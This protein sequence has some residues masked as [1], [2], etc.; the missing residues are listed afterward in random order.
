MALNEQRF[1]SPAALVDAVYDWSLPLLQQAIT[2]Q[3]RCSLLLSGGTTPLPYYRKLAAAPLPWPN[4]QLALVDERW[5]AT[6]D[7]LSNELAIRNAFASNPVAQQQILGMKNSAASAQTGASLCNQY[8]QN[9]PWPPAL[10][11][12]GMGNDGHTASLF[13]DAEGLDAALTTQT[14]CAAIQAKP[15]AITGSCTER[16]TLTL[17][18]LLQC[19]QLALVITGAEKWRIYEKAKK[20]ADRALP[21]SLLLNQAKQLAVFWCP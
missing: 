16:M 14:Y 15:S 10:A 19:Q 7:A 18:A 17:W 13:P 2:K 21:I 11:V 5:V 1:D 20:H 3:Q 9:L 6:T 8:Y 4:L 12:L